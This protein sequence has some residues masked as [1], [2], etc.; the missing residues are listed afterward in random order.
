MKK[1]SYIDCEINPDLNQVLDLGAVH[2][3]NIF[4][5]VNISDFLNFIEDSD[6]ICGHNI[7]QHDIK[8]LQK[9]RHRPVLI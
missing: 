8:Y 5:S 3:N 7:I 2:L 1:I 6:Y 4:H 9:R